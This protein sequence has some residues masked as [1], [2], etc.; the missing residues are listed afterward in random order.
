MSAILNGALREIV[1]RLAVEGV[2]D[3][4]ASRLLVDLRADLERE[5]LEA[6]LRRAR[7]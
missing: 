2:R 3:C 5:Q 4:E 7:T 6:W 1:A